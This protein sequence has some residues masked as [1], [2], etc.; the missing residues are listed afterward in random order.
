[1]LISLSGESSA[2]ILFELNAPQV[3][4]RW[5]IAHS[6]FFRT[7]TAIG[8]IIPLQSDARSPG[9]LSR[10]MLERQLGQWFRWAVPEFSF[11]TVIPHFLQTKTSF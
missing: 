2:A 1:M 6:P 4:Q 5:I 8:S 10:C 11:V 9:V 3:L 7:H